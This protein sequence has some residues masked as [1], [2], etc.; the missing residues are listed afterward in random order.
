M[1]NDGQLSTHTDAEWG[2]LN[3]RF[4]AQDVQINFVGEN[5]IIAH[6]KIGD[7][8]IAIGQHI[9][10]TAKRSEYEHKFTYS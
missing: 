2:T 8:H 9:T 10:V 4:F 6:L 5:F 3:D 7:V 1:G